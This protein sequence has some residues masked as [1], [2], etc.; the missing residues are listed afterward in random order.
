[1]LVFYILVFQSKK[2]TVKVAD[3]ETNEPPPMANKKIT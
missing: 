3:C 1:M 2:Y